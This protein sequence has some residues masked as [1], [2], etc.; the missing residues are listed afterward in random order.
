[1]IHFF[2]NEIFD[3]AMQMCLHLKTE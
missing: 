1:M 3:C 2:L